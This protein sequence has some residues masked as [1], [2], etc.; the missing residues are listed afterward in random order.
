MTNGPGPI[1]DAIQTLRS[2]TELGDA[3]L[4]LYFLA[5]LH[6]YFWVIDHNALA[7]I[8]SAAA[9]IVFW[10]LYISTKQFSAEKSGRSFWLIVGLP[11]LVAYLMRA[12]FPDRS[13]DVLN[14]HLLHAERSLRGALFGPGD[15][16]PSPVPLNPA[17]DTLTGIS[18]FV[19]G[20]RLGTVI[21]LFA[22]IWTA[23]IA[24][25]IL[26][27]LIARSWLRSACVLVVML[28][29]HLLFEIST[30]M[31]DLLALPLLLQATLLTLRA[32]EPK[33][34]R[35]NFVH[36][37]LLLGLSAAFKLTNLA[38][39]LPVLAVCIYKLAKGSG[40][41]RPREM[42][43]TGP[44]MLAAFLASLVPFTIY[45][46]RLTG[47]PIFPVANVFFNSPYWP[48][49]GGWDNRWGPHG[50]WE[51]IVWPVLVWFRPERHSELAVYSGRLSFGFV[52]AIAGM[53]LAWRNKGARTLCLILLSSSV[54]WSVTALGYSRYGLYQEVLAGI[55]VFA[56][57]A[58]LAEKVSWP[59][60]SWRSALAAVFVVVLVAQSY[61]ACSYSWQ[62]EWGERRTLIDAPASYFRGAKLMLRDRSLI[63]FVSAE[64]R[65][66]LDQVQVW[67]E[68]SPKTTGFE[69]LL[70]P[71]API[72]AAR[73]PEYFFTR[74]AWRQFIHTVEASSGQKMFSL[75]LNEDLANAR[76]VIAQRG[77]EVGS[78]TP[79]KLPFF[80]PREWMG[81]MLIEIRIPEEPEARRNFETAWMKGAFASADYREEIVA[82]NPPA[83]MH[84]GEKV[85]I[86]LKVRNL[87]AATWPA[88]GTKD[89]RY[90]INMGDR[91]IRDGITS[92]DNRAV[93]NADLPPGG[94]TEIRLTVNAPGT[95]GD[96]TLEI[97]MVHEGVT[98]F[99]E[100][101]ARA[102]QLPV[103][104]QN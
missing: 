6:Q 3:L 81:M 51:T 9:A 48:T 103:R 43:T 72:I 30:Y 77:L 27:P 87:G 32:D 57:A 2:K 12:A 21:N 100:R 10:Y 47:N 29:E 99:K 4:F 13:F 68:T 18:R 85:D 91:W 92:E 94:E 14:Y 54:L 60:V 61:L 52:V 17:A 7:W 86:R 59:P 95:P 33:N 80:S 11:L 31:I 102:L 58:V 63:S 5:L 45:I 28:S 1:R 74:Q 24:D 62:K 101:G 15:F 37:A 41:F 97:D 46:F 34:R 79:V 82:F 25:K 69:V 84:P 90:Q 16:F 35:A 66:L 67:F 8:L 89:F 70:N 22:L 76:Q 42:L 26:R 64:E 49:H 55:T 78:V 39:V 19:L 75:C 88:V 53:F 40:R 96:Y 104:V 98:W 38:V 65:T 56:V 83:V 93:M 71:G 20:Y 36:I 50:F 73:Q 23:Q 44:L